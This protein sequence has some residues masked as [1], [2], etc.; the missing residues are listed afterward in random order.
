LKNKEFLL[1]QKIAHRGI[2]DI[3]LE[4]TLPAFEE[5]IKYH[6]TIELDVRLSK[7]NVV[8]VFHDDNLKRIFGI[9]RDI[10]DLT[11]EEIKKYQYIPTLE[12]TLSFIHGQVPIII[13]IKKD[14][15]TKVFIAKLT[16]LLDNYQGKF[17]IQTFYPLTLLWF[18]LYRPQ[19]IK[20]YL[21]YD[22]FFDNILYS[23]ILNQ[24][25]LKNILRPDYIG[26]NLSALKERKIQA[27]RK[28]Y[29]VI[30]YTIQNKKQ[31]QKY[32]Q[33]ADN[34]IY[35][36]KKQETVPLWTASQKE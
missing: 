35:D 15:R 31:Y 11:L 4:N 24:L 7:D 6:D 26:V 27:L 8:V 25:I 22:A 5:A 2:H 28:N 9:N 20:G 13:E 10:Q 1:K 32:K 34:F 3:F 16:K 30:G 12:E 21:I 17:A 23:L 33:Y 36:I 29:I 19:Y 18:T 14:R